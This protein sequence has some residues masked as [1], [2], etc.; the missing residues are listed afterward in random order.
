MLTSCGSTKTAPSEKKRAPTIILKDFFLADNSAEYSDNITKITTIKAGPALQ[1]GT[2]RTWL[3][4]AP[5]VGV[6]LNELYYDRKEITSKSQFLVGLRASYNYKHFE[7]GANAST[8]EAGMFVG[9]T[10]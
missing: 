9:Y 4:L 6:A 5:Y 3:T 7:I 2:A 1:Y 8:K 10:F